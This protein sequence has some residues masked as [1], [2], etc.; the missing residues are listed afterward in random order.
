MDGDDFL[1]RIVK[2]SKD[3]FWWKKRVSTK[4]CAAYQRKDKIHLAPYHV[5]E[6]GLLVLRP[7]FVNLDI[8]ID[9]EELGNKLIE[10]LNETKIGIHHPS[11]FDPVERKEWSVQPL[12]HGFKM[13]SYK[14]FVRGNY[15]VRVKMDKK[16]MS[17]MPSKNM[18]RKDGWRDLSESE[19]RIIANSTP[20][21]IG[22]TL[23]CAF[24]LSTLDYE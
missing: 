13:K 18:G 3:Y 23:R 9:N 16:R 7:P 11:P 21:L 20:E 8:N 22:K 19:I 12:A 15:C 4:Y 17:F 10:I 1:R 5:T 14:E 24:D 6:V 2:G